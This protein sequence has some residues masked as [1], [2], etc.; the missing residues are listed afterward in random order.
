MAEKRGYGGFGYT[1]N[2]FRANQGYRGPPRESARGPVLPRRA[3]FPAAQL[4]IHYIK[5]RAGPAHFGG[6][7]RFKRRGRLPVDS[8]NRARRRSHRLNR[9]RVENGAGRAE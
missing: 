7:G 4:N 9:L 3:R 2:L 6:H 1:R 5:C 8:V